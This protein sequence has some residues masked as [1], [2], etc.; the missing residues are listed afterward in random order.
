MVLKVTNNVVCSQL[1]LVKMK[2]TKRKDYSKMNVNIVEF[3][4]KNIL[5]IME[6]KM[7][8]SPRPPQPYSTDQELWDIV[9]EGGNIPKIKQVSMKYTFSDGFQE[10]QS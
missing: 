9:K 4:I 6:F 3:L 1:L 2:L 7:S 10:K 8:D 5:Q